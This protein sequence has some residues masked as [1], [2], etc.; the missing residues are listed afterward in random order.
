MFLRRI[1]ASAA[2]RHDKGLIPR[3]Q[4]LGKLLTSLWNKICACG[5]VAILRVAV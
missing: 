3:L 1:V 4:L 5:R 2:A